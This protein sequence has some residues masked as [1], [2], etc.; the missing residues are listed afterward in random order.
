SKVGAP[1]G[2]GHCNF[3]PETYVGT[4]MLM[5]DWVRNGL[6]PTPGVIEREL[7]ADSGYSSAFTPGPWPGEG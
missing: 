7:G 3:T 5:E 6:V 1:Y 4:A 2:A